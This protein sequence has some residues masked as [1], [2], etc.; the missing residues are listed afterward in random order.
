MEVWGSRFWASVGIE[1]D[2]IGAFSRF[3]AIYNITEGKKMLFVRLSTGVRGISWVY[4]SSG[5][6]A[7]PSRTGKNIMCPTLV[8]KGPSG[9]VTK[10][11]R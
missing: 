6:S 7:D 8:F 3:Y 1:L 10:V 11:L 9:D 4:I 5:T 2:R